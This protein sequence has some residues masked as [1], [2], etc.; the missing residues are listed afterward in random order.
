M[1]VTERESVGVG[2]GLFEDVG[3][4]VGVSVND[5][6]LDQEGVEEKVMS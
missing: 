3:S 1:K 4:L 5:D 6:V 2:V